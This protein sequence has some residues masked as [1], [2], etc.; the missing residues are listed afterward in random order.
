MTTGSVQ[1]I[2]VCVPAPSASAKQQA[3]CPAV[4][5]QYYVPATIQAY[6]LDPAQQNDIDAALGPFDYGYASAIWSLAFSTV[7]GLYFFS[8]AIS[9]IL[10]L[11]RRG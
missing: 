6:V 2:V 11:I 4:G 1:T 9:Q 3:T 8:N 7:V 5:T 10:G